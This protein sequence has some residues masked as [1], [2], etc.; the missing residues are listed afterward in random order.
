MFKKLTLVVMALTLFLAFTIHDNADARRGGGY[1]SGT[2]SYTTIP[3][4]S[5]DSV[6]KSSSTTNRNGATGASTNRGFFSGGGF[7]KGMMIGGLAGML[8]GGMFSGMGFFGN[9]LGFAVNLFAIYL[10]V[11]IAVA[12]FRRFRQKPNRPRD[13]RY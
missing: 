5:N 9:I 4:K 3:K 2:R 8:F 1:K 7:W 6:S 12:L 13:D 10:I 11:V